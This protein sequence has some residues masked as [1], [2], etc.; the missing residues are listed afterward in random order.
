MKKVGAIF[1]LIVFSLVFASALASAASTGDAFRPI[2]EMVLGAGSVVVDILN[3]VLKYVLGD[4]NGLN[5][6]YDDA[7]TGLFIAR[8]MILIITFAIAYVAITKTQFF[9]SIPWA[10]WVVSAGV[11][12]LGVRFLS[13]EFIWNVILPNAALAF[14]V[15]AGLPFVA[16][17]LIVKDWKSLTLQ[18]IAWVA[19][20]VAMFLLWTFTMYGVGTDDSAM[21]LVMGFYPITAVLALI[22]AAISGAIKRTSIRMK[23]ESANAEAVNEQ[24]LEKKRQLKQNAQDFADRT[25]DESE[26]NKRKKKIS[27]EIAALAKSL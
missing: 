21:N 19:F 11:G 12:I 17:F 1:A 27:D 22:M 9:D 7:N 5:S 4:S 3:P 15:T 16:F 24:I 14:V 26:F 18:R 25:I 23:A 8:I 10:K 6:N 20:A 2:G 13:V